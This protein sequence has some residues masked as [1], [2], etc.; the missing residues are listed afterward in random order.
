MKISMNSTAAFRGTTARD[1]AV[2]K[3]AGYD[4]SLVASTMRNTVRMLLA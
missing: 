2:A 1:I 3:A 4:A